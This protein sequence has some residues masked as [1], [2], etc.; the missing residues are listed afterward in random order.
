VRKA[1]LENEP[2]A[3]VH[4]A[5]AK[6]KREL[7]WAPRHPSWRTGFAAAYSALAL[8]DGLKSHPAPRTSHS[9]G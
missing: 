4:Q 7:G 5:T 3:I 1:V 6:A 2:E 8:A 9:P